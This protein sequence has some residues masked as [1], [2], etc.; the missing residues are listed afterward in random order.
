MKGFCQLRRYIP[1]DFELCQVALL[2]LYG[3]ILDDLV[4]ERWD[5]RSSHSDIAQHVLY[6]SALANS[7]K[8]TIESGLLTIP[9]I[10]GD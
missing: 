6:Q 10:A 5:N 3:I 9:V 8:T 1:R 2:N 4:F 7:F